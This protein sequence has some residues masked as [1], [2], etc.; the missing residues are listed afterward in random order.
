MKPQN[1][2]ALN[3][4]SSWSLSQSEDAF[5]GV[6]KYLTS[7][8]EPCGGSNGASHGV[9]EPLVK[10]ELSEKAI[11]IGNRSNKSNVSGST[12]IRQQLGSKEL[13]YKRNRIGNLIRNYISL[14]LG[15]KSKV[16]GPENPQY[17]LKF[18]YDTLQKKQNKS[19][20]SGNTLAFLRME[21]VNFFRS[22]DFK[23]AYKSRWPEYPTLGKEPSAPLITHSTCHF[24]AH[25]QIRTVRLFFKYRKE[26]ARKVK[27]KNAADP[28]VDCDTLSDTSVPL[29]TSYYF[30]NTQDL[31]YLR[32]PETLIEQDLRLNNE[33]P[34]VS[35]A[36]LYARFLLDLQEPNHDSFEDLKKCSSVIGIQASSEDE[37]FDSYLN[38]I[39]WL[40]EHHFNKPWTM[41]ELRKCEHGSQLSSFESKNGKPLE[42]ENAS[43]NETKFG[44]GLYLEKKR[45]IANEESFEKMRSSGR[46]EA[47]RKKRKPTKSNTQAVEREQCLSFK[48][49][50]TPSDRVRGEDSINFTTQSFPDGTKLRL[51]K[52]LQDWEPKVPLKPP[53]NALFGNVFDK[54]QGAKS[55]VEKLHTRTASNFFGRLGGKDEQLQV[56]SFE[57]NHLPPEHKTD[58]L[59]HTVYD[60]KSQSFTPNQSALR[61]K[62]SAFSEVL[63]SHVYLS[64]S[65][66]E[67]E[68]FAKINLRDPLQISIVGEEK[69][70]TPIRQQ[71]IPRRLA[72]LGSP[73]NKTR[74]NRSGFNGREGNFKLSTHE[75][76]DPCDFNSRDYS[77]RDEYMFGH[78]TCVGEGA[79]NAEQPEIDS[80]EHESSESETLS[81]ESKPKGTLE[82]CGFQI[83][84]S[85]RRFEEELAL[86]QKNA[87]LLFFLGHSKNQRSTIVNTRSCL[88][89]PHDAKFS[90][91]GSKNT[92]PEELGTFKEH[93][94]KVIMAE[95]TPQTSFSKFA[96]KC[97]SRL[98]LNFSDQRESIEGIA[99]KCRPKSNIGEKRFESSGSQ[100]FEE[101]FLAAS[102]LLA[103]EER[104]NLEEQELGQNFNDPFYRP[105]ASFSSKNLFYDY[106]QEP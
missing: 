63:E 3:R 14:S 20:Q 2:E 83:N 65:E 92:S 72:N 9:C 46:R 88:F 89:H 85:E 51:D 94:K 27:L 90:F 66:K 17:T 75:H 33:T 105:S 5:F 73:G 34:E 93:L 43:G 26:R 86:I 10:S 55:H 74:K 50:T 23:S 97:S 6:R 15:R 59:K 19:K 58:S 56:S 81:S 68:C 71:D 35:A 106:E 79:T 32:Y 8:F 31:D 100:C 13:F 95:S 37:S 64:S 45:R 61:D 30:D 1:H 29:K 98:N 18:H 36:Q 41:L 87:P 82:K 38:T 11:L 47:S 21:T 48:Y 77:G 104:V 70:K 53:I 44:T 84:V 60:K 102:S 39:E 80:I 28:Q 24:D 103:P 22:F 96:H 52:Y 76:G 49:S 12:E 25:P 67:K 16:R 78:E 54:L 40:A 42:Q 7:F 99:G 57:F 91:F 101:E 62:F 4:L 69:N